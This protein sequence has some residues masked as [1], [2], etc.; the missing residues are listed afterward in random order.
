M[1]HKIDDI[2]S[3]QHEKMLNF[4]PVLVCFEQQLY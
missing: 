2:I 3:S 4:P 1:W